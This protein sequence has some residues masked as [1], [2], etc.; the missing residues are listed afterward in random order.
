MFRTSL[1]NLADTETL[2]RS[3]LD[4]GRGHPI[5]G[6]F[7]WSLGHPMNPPSS[8][9]S[10]CKEY[11]QRSC[12]WSTRFSA[13]GR[14]RSARVARMPARQSRRGHRGSARLDGRRTSCIWRIGSPSTTLLF[15]WRGGRVSKTRPGPAR[16]STS[17]RSCV[18][19][20]GHLVPLEKVRGRKKVAVRIA[21]PSGER[22]ALLAPIAEQTVF[23]THGDCIDDAKWLEKK[24]RE[25]FRRRKTSASTDRRP[26][27]RCA[28]RPGHHGA[29]LPASNRD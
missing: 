7:Q 19:D 2:F 10:N 29:V 15:L 23:I 6:L 22:P 4:Q 17:S 1:P 13:S 14:P 25:R 18:D 9:Q 28:F 27:H 5:P 11:P 12:P 20:D 8:S 3:L 26:R 24:I 21:R 16:C